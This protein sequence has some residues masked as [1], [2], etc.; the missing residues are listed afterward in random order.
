MLK[1]RELEKTLQGKFD[2]SPAPNRSSDHRW[3]EL[4]LPGLPTIAT[5]VSHSRKEIGRNLEGKIARQLR[6]RKKFFQEMVACTQSQQDY[7]QQ[8][9]TDPYPPFDVRF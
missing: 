6:V 3:Y 4:T 5:K 2:F 1:P 9:R 8:V 7:Y